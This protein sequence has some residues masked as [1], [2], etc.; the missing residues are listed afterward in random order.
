MKH[1][2]HT[3]IGGVLL[4]LSTMELAFPLALSYL[5]IL[6]TLPFFISAYNK[7]IDDTLTMFMIILSIFYMTTVIMLFCSLAQGTFLAMTTV[8][9]FQMIMSKNT[10]KL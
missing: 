4:G 9:A 8:M 10:W 2:L 7:R 6:F 5:I 1:F 3:I